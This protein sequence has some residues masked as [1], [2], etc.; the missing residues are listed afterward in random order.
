M[1][2]FVFCIYSYFK[3]NKSSVSFSEENNF[4]KT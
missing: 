2:I 1:V 4:K 3:I